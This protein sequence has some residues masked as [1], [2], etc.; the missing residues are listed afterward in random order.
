[1]YSL[2]ISWHHM[3]I[4]PFTLVFRFQVQIFKKTRKIERRM[5]RQMLSLKNTEKLY[6]NKSTFELLRAWTILSVC[7]RKWIVSPSVSMLR[8]TESTTIA[9]MLLRRTIWPH[10]C[11]GESIEDCQDVGWNMKASGVRLMLDRSVEERESEEDWAINLERKK[12]LLR[13]CKDSFGDDAVFVR[14]YQRKMF[15]VFDTYTSIHTH[16]TQHNTDHD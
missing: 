2:S 8:S 11:A 15:C 13:Q 9:S 14:T 5:F 10:F 4:F 12:S 1:M 16:T 3:S 6:K 7:K